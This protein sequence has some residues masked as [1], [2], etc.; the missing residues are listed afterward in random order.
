MG[1]VEVIAVMG[2]G[3]I[4]FTP[5]PIVRCRDCD[6]HSIVKDF[7]GTPIY[8]CRRFA[9]YHQTEPDG[10]CHKGRRA[11]HGADR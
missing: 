5:T 11:E 6:K 9:A 1:S 3:I 8:V 2:E 7:D 4:E 10:Y